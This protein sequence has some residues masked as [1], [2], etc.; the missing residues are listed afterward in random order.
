MSIFKLP[1]LIDV[2]V[3]LRDMGQNHKEDFYTGTAAALAGG[4][5]TIIDMPNKTEPITTLERLDAERAEGAKKTVC[6]LGFHFGSLGE[7]LDEFAKVQDKVLGLKLYLN[8]TTGGF[9]I[10]GEVMKNIYEA[11]VKVSTKPILLHSEEDTVSMVTEVIKATGQRSHFCHVS[12]EHELSQIIEAKEVGLPVT[13]G[14]CPHHLFLTE[15]DV[16]HLGAYGRMKPPLKTRRDVEFIWKNIHHVDVIETDHAPH[17]KEEKD[18]DN[19]PFG[20]PG[21]ETALPLMLKAEKEG[22]VTRADIIR[23]MHT[24][25]AKIFNLKTDDSTYIEVSDEEYEIRNEDMKT[26]CGW[27]PFAGWKVPGKVKRVFIR[28]QKVYEDGEV[29]AAGGNG[30]ILP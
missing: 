5:T 16:A 21:L 6:D 20:V 25:P 30:T 11:W 13:C 27:T 22:K 1:G 28:G 10:N 7:N 26:K 15:D 17:T 3:H 2:H 8:L 23:L 18:S 14:V 4:F 24:N 9:I 19:P 12:S 29:L